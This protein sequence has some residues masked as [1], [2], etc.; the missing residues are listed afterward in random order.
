MEEIE[1]K[2]EQ[3]SKNVKLMNPYGK[4][5]DYKTAKVSSGSQSGELSLEFLARER[6][7]KLL[8]AS[9]NSDTASSVDSSK[10]KTKEVSAE[11]KEVEPIVNPLPT[12][13]KRVPRELDF[14]IQPT[15]EDMHFDLVDLKG[16]DYFDIN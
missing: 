13:K 15:D 1:K 16:M 12:P 8:E 5:M 11:H 3:P 14:D 4:R 6:E 7:K 9:N 10:T 2:T